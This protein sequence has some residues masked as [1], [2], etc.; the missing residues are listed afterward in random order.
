MSHTNTITSTVWDKSKKISSDTGV[1]N[2]DMEL[3]FTST[4]RGHHNKVVDPFCT[5]VFKI[6]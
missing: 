2:L 5:T 1:T 6:P 3:D 4:S